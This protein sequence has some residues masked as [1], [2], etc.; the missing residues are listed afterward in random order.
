MASQPVTGPRRL[1]ARWRPAIAAAIL[2][3]VVLSWDLW[4]AVA[5]FVWIAVLSIAAALGAG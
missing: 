2:T 4:R 3:G 5:W 1:L